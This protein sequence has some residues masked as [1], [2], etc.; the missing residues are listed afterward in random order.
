MDCVGGH[1][2]KITLDS[3]NGSDGMLRADW[4][5]SYSGQMFFGFSFY[6]AS[7]LASDFKEFPW[8]VNDG[9]TNYLGGGYFIFNS[10]ENRM[11]AY[12]DGG[13]ASTDYW[14]I[15]TATEYRMVIEFD[16]GANPNSLGEL[17]LYDS[18]GDAVTTNLS[19]TSIDFSTRNLA[20]ERATWDWGDYVS[21]T[22]AIVYIDYAVLANTLAEAKAIP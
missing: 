11:H 5:G 12:G 14:V 16:Q 21:A 17:Y 15:S 9:E 1:S 19:N 22:E 2:L 18:N 20:G 3:D 7:N 6:L 4:S 8:I 10:G 13:P